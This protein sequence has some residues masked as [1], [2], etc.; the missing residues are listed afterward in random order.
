MIQVQTTTINSIA[1]QEGVSQPQFQ[2]LP[3]ASG[4][5]LVQIPQPMATPGT[6]I[7]MAS[8]E[9]AAQAGQGGKL[10]VM[11]QPT[12]YKLGKYHRLLFGVGSD[13]SFFTSLNEAWVFSF[14]VSMLVSLSA[15][16]S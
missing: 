7:V 11:Q 13:A 6:R 5:M 4:Q 3:T 16:S 12:T 1:G 9:M 8:P 14:G 15:T 10:V 2:M